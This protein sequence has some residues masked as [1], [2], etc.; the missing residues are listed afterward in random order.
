MAYRFHIQGGSEWWG[1]NFNWESDGTAGLRRGGGT[2]S[3]CK[4]AFQKPYGLYLVYSI[5]FLN[6]L[7]FIFLFYL[8]IF[9]G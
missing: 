2:I 5:C 3:N 8:F 4:D 7:L 9:F 1:R 6:F